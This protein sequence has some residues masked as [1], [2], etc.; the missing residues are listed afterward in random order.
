MPLLLVPFFVFFVF[1]VASFFS[2]ETVSDSGFKKQ[3]ATKNTK[4]TKN[5]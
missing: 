2:A 5:N 3:L 4:D 1:F